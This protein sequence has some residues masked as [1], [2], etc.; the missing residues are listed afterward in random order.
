MSDLYNE[1][2]VAHSLSQQRRYELQQE[3]RRTMLNE[4]K[5][6]NL[7]RMTT[8]EAVSL[9]A[10]GRAMEAE[11]SHVGSEAPDWL[12]DNLKELRREI[13][14]RTRDSLEARL[15]EAK[16]RLESLSTT[17]EKRDKLRREIEALSGKLSAGAQG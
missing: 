15:N 1:R 3:G 16:S 5:N 14:N 8:E 10:F 13:R 7:V 12:T 11:F 17:E 6:L 2:K 9:A 4:L